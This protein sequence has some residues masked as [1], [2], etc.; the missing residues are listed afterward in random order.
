MKSIIVGIALIINFNILFAHKE[1]T[2]QFITREA[3]KLLRFELG[4]DI[5]VL[6][7]YLNLIENSQSDPCL[8][9]EKTYPYLCG[10]VTG[11]CW[12]ED[13]QDPVYNLDVGLLASAWVSVSHFW[14]SD[15]GK[16][17]KVD[18]GTI[19]FTHF[20]SK[21]GVNA[22]RKAIYYMGGLWDMKLNIGNKAYKI[23][24]RGLTNFLKYGDV[25]NVNTS[26]TVNFET[27]IGISPNNLSVRKEIVFNI[28]GR[29]VHLLQDMGVP[30]HVHNEQHACTLFSSNT[31]F[32]NCD[33]FEQMMDVEGIKDPYAE[34][35]SDW[36]D[37]RYWS[38]NKVLIKK[39]GKVKI[40]CN[41]PITFLMYTANQ[42]TDHFASREHDGDDKYEHI[43]E[44]DYILSKATG[45][46]KKSFYTSI[47]NLNPPLVNMAK[48]KD[49]LIGVRDAVFTYSIRATASLLLKFACDAG[50]LDEF[51]NSNIYTGLADYKTEDQFYPSA[52]GND[53]KLSGYYYEFQAKRSVIAGKIGSNSNH[54]LTIEDKTIADLH[55][56]GLVNLR[57]GFHATAGIEAT[58]LLYISPPSYCC[59][60]NTTT[61]ELSTN[62]N[63]QTE[64]EIQ[65][66]PVLKIELKEMPILPNG[67]KYKEKTNSSEFTIA[68]YP[69]PL[70][71]ETRIEY[72]VP[73]KCKLKIIITNANGEEIKKI[74]SESNHEKGIY[75]VDWNV[76]KEES[77]VYYCV[78]SSEGKQYVKTL[79]LK[80]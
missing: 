36:L 39:G 27:L 11:G 8:G 43:G 28:L 52:F 5:D 22:Y 55:A 25:V 4:K 80:K 49:G 32:Q 33:P 59:N 23:Y 35:I 29:V 50:L 71:K 9:N 45:P 64:E 60:T 79:I 46:T 31:G 74:V 77:G 15:E 3:Y 30:A 44:I 34:N 62:L 26:R 51:T 21:K 13:Q 61:I 54:T 48:D 24:Y 76:E 20:E 17:S 37:P 16:D 12:A 65:T 7:D 18:L 42:I 2:H 53:V 41:E 19:W 40:N 67:V 75:E 1:Y 6:K 38:W 47:D 56:G 57:A 68:A 78:L 70:L 72:T 69:N 14:N 66:N 63:K 58:S 73:S 10:N